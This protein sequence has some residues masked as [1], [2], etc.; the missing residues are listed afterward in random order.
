M[1]QPGMTFWNWLVED[2]R[3][4]NVT[5]DVRTSFRQP[6]TSGSGLPALNIN[7]ETVWHSIG[8]LGPGHGRG[9]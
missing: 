5:E 6:P 2:I 3:H 8:F 1:E 9:C 4:R 7:S